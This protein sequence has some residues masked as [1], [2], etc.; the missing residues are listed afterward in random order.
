MIDRSLFKPFHL[1]ILQILDKRVASGKNRTL[2][3]MPSST[4]KT[5]LISAFL[6]DYFL[7]VKEHTRILIVTSS[8]AIKQQTIKRLKEILEVSVGSIE[9][10]HYHQ[11]VIA[12]RSEFE[13]KIP[14]E[15]IKDSL[16]L[17]IFTDFGSGYEKL[18]MEINRPRSVF[19]IAFTNDAEKL[20]FF[21]EYDYI[22]SYKDALKDGLLC[23]LKVVKVELGMNESE[24]A[25]HK[26]ISELD[27]EM[28]IAKLNQLISNS[29]SY[30]RLLCSDIIA[31]I[32]NEKTLVVSPSINHA[33]RITNIFNELKRSDA[34]AATIHTSKA[35]V[36]INRIIDF[37]DD[38]LSTLR[39]LVIV[40][41]ASAIS[42]IRNIQNVIPLRS[43]SNG[44]VLRTALSAALIASPTK[45]HLKLIDYVGATKY[46]TKSFGNDFTIDEIEEL[47]VPRQFLAQTNISFRDKR[48]IE[49]VLAAG[50]LAEELAEI[51]K[52]IP[53]EQGSMIGIFGNWGRGKTFLMDLVWKELEKN[54]KFTK[55]DFHAWR[56]QDTPATWAYLYERLAE[57]YFNE[58]KEKWYWPRSFSSA[59][60]QLKLNKAR[61]GWIP[62]LKIAGI[63]CI[64]IIIITVANRYIQ[65]KGDI[66][67]LVKIP[68]G[69]TLVGYSLWATL[70]RD[71]QAKA[72]DIFLKYSSKHSFE[73]HLG[74]QAEIQK[75][76]LK[77]LKCWIPKKNTGKKKL[78]LFVD[79]IDRCNEAKVIQIIDSLRVLLED[80]EIAERIV[81]LAAIDE[82]FLRLAIKN[83]YS[84]LLAVEKK[85][86]DQ[87]AKDLDRV[88]D[89]YMDKLFIS[90]VKLGSLSD[91]DRDD[92][93]LSLTKADRAE[94]SKPKTLEEILAHEQ[95]FIDARTSQHIMD[96]IVEDQIERQQEQQ[97]YDELEFENYIEEDFHTEY[98]DF[99]ETISVEGQ[100]EHK[101]ILADEE[102]DILRYAATMFHEATPRQIRIFYYRYLMAKNLLARRYR[103][104]KLNNIWMKTRYSL[105]VA[106]LIIAYTTNHLSNLKQQNTTIEENQVDKK[107]YETLQDRLAKA[108]KSR[109][110][111]M[112]VVP[113]EKVMVGTSDY[114][115]LLKVLDI[116]IAY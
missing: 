3:S 68:A 115:E 74:L 54:K 16:R 111:R 81:I 41:L 113:L 90:G 39:I 11:V 31:R 88:T 45:S 23:P 103:S 102:V 37:F 17:V 69:L 35:T 48:N 10:L 2:I 112:K 27:S 28:P 71:Y 80:H 109:E 61:N 83:K 114:R 82:R 29:D 101:G 79:D 55:I 4:G 18:F 64:N 22:Y 108:M 53:G 30:L 50:D 43:N 13:N 89:E 66:S 110:P 6:E 86:P 52:I 85:D 58:E 46:L 75:E 9:D 32:S 26:L 70:K 73:S 100:S 49:P 12:H 47:K 96:M 34:I 84:S 33:E 94:D 65:G 42:R 25:Y 78:V 19:N 95:N 24:Q 62:F 5:F 59:W 7:D 76:T 104:L 72:K 60:R 105:I 15:S 63:L 20:G 107:T 97:M 87:Q 38:P 67:D 77:L 98:L 44:S 106:R 8:I 93:I 14:L 92:F 91:S 1:E 21:G 57:T 56:Y 116:V 36:D 40:D 51:I 99:S